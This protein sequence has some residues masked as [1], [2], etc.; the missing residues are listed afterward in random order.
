MLV[1]LI[2]HGKNRLPI[3][4]GW[5]SHTATQKL[6]WGYITSKPSNSKNL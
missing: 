5:F 2:K 4:C 1:D 6:V 3:L